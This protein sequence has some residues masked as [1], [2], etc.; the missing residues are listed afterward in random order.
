MSYRAVID[1]PEGGWSWE[2]FIDVAVAHGVNIAA[3]DR[4]VLTAHRML[5]K[6]E[7][8]AKKTFEQKGFNVY[9]VPAWRKLAQ[10]CDE[11]AEHG[12]TLIDTRAATPTSEG[13]TS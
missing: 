13:A 11:A 5:K 8:S 10:Q 2:D 4:A 9:Y 6:S 3:T 7:S 1:Q 12:P